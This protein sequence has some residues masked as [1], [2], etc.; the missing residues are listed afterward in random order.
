LSF[1]RTEIP[2]DLTAEWFYLDEGEEPGK[3][4][5]RDL[6]GLKALQ[7]TWIA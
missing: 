7:D 4:Y 2:D 6:L 1:S 5:D 3:L